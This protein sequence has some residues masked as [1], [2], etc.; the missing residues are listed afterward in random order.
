MPGT[1][2][3]RLPRLQ[4]VAKEHHERIERRR[5]LLVSQRKLFIRSGT[6][7]HLAALIR[8]RTRTEVLANSSFFVGHSRVHGDYWAERL[9]QEHFTVVDF[10]L[11]A[12]PG[13]SFLVDGLA[14]G[15]RDPAARGRN[16]D[17][18]LT[19]L[20]VDRLVRHSGD[21]AAVD[22]QLPSFVAMFSQ[23]RSFQLSAFVLRV[24]ISCMKSAW[25]C[26]PR[27]VAP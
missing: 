18:V 27:G 25:A 19:T 6:A 17:P 8:P 26:I 9:R 4:I 2:R 12:R 15:R 22:V 3:G 1:S 20:L 5:M 16:G 23:N 11:P 14:G 21:A 24:P 10:R 13:G 7:K